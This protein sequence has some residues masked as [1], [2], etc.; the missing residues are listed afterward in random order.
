[1][2]ITQL[3]VAPP[4]SAGGELERLR[5]T[6]RRSADNGSDDGG[7]SVRCTNSVVVEC[8]GQ[9]RAFGRSAR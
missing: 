4:T 8:A 3:M 2:A 7:A 1:M 9:Q 6:R 5:G